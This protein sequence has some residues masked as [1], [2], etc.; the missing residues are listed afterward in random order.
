[1]SIPN[2]TQSPVSSFFGQKERY[3]KPTIHLAEGLLIC[4][5]TDGGL[6]DRFRESIQ[7]PVIKYERYR[8]FERNRTVQV[9]YLLAC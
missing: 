8:V 7:V 2:K 9:L 4:V 1:M 5:R 6:I 3:Y